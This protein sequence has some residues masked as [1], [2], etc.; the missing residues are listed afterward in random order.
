MSRLF[1]ENRKEC[2]WYDYDSAECIGQVTYNQHIN[3]PRYVAC[4]EDVCP[5]FY[6]VAIQGG[7]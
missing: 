2:P 1:Q 4:S 7:E 6:W 5:V 3:D